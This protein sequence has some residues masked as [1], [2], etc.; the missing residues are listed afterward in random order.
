MKKNS[1]AATI[2]MLSFGWLAIWVYRTVLSPAYSSIAGEL[3]ITSSAMLGLI[4]SCYFLGYVAVQV[5]G[6]FLIDRFGRRRVLLPG[7][8]LFLLGS[9]VVCSAGSLFTLYLGSTI[10][11]LGTGVY[12]AGAFSLSAE[13]IPAGSRTLST[14]LVNSGSAVGMVL[15]YSISSLLVGSLGLSWRVPVAVAAVAAAAATA[16]LAA[17]LDSAPPK[18]ARERADLRRI[19]SPPVLTSCI[20]Y[21]GTCYG[22]Y[23]IVTWLPS[24]LQ[25][26]RSFSATAAGLVASIVPLAS[27]PGAIVFGRL[28]DR[29]AGRRVQFLICMQLLSALLLVLAAATSSVALTMACFVIYGA[30]GKIAEDPL[31][32]LHVTDRLGGRRVASGLSVFNCIGM[33]ASVLAPSVSGA[34]GDATGSGVGGFYLSVAVLLLSALIFLLGNRD[35]GKNS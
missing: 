1:A 24:F 22:Y 17:G 32:V 3:G 6:G 13:R 11:G 14:A 27:I 10:A 8:G 25:T 16:F 9:L 15:G 28:V 2:A 26:E 34:I 31:I 4:S 18:G 35:R 5:P 7:F 19:L 30:T 21:F 33:S 12:Y 23:M 20:F 29:F